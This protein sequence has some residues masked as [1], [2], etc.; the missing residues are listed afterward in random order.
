MGKRNFH[1]KQRLVQK[2]PEGRG[3]LSQIESE[4]IPGS[5]KKGSKLL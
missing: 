5:N 1:I 3:R 2:K 4:I